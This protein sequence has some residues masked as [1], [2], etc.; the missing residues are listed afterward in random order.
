MADRF[1]SVPM[2]LSDLERRAQAADLTGG[3]RDLERLKS[4]GNTCG[5]MRVAR[6]HTRPHALMLRRHPSVP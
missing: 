2:I 4:D 3:S 6:G 5:E 1:V